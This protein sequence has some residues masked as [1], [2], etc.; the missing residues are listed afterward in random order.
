M[1]L[2]RGSVVTAGAIS[3]RLGLGAGSTVGGRVGI[4]IDP[5]LLAKL[6]AGRQVALV[7]GTNGKTTTTR[8]LAEALGGPGI[9]ATSLAGANMPAGLVAALCSTPAPT[10]PAVL[11]VDEGYLGDVD[12]SVRPRVVVALNLS[13]D[14]LDRVGEVRMVAARWREAFAATKA[15]VVANCDDP[16]VAWAAIAARHVVWVAAGGIW[17]A[18]AHHCPSCD[19]RVDFSAA[20]TS[21]WSCTCGLR[22]PRPEAALTDHALRIG[23][24]T[25]PFALALPGRFNR[26]NAAMAAVAASVLGIDAARALEAMSRVDDIAGRFAVVTDGSLSARL[27]LAKNPAGWTE[28]VDLL[29]GGTGP[30]VVAVNARDAD[31]RDPSWLW[32]VPFERLGERRVVATGERRDD[33]AVRLRH[34]GVAHATVRDQIDALHAAHRAGSGMG[35][36]SAGVNATVDY[37]GNYT[38]FQEL[39]RR[40]GRSP[41]TAAAPTKTLR[42]DAQPSWTV[43]MP[44]RPRSADTIRPDSSDT[45]ISGPGPGPGPGPGSGSGSGSGRARARRSALSVVVVHPDLLGTYGDGGNG[46]VLADRAEWRGIP[47]ELVVAP[48]DGPLP[49]SADLYC[50]GGGEDGPQSR[51]A[52][53]LA[54]GS[55]EDALARGATVLAVCAG[56]QILGHSFPGPGGVPQPGLGLLD[57]ATV[58]GTGPRAVGEVVAEVLAPTALGPAALASTALGP[59]ALGPT[60]LGPTALGP[61][62][63]GPT[64]AGDHALLTG[65]VN[66]AGETRIGPGARPL[67]RLLSGDG[68]TRS[69]APPA[70]GAVAGTVVATYLH[71]PVLARNPALADALLSMATG[72]VLEP[73]DDVEEDALRVERLRGS[74]RKIGTGTPRARKIG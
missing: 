7:S 54:D 60:A 73:L 29:A 25:V 17:H 13:R 67:A 55:L 59:T 57:V 40:V 2:A 37:V 23:D 31:G 38:A 71:G 45:T 24:R 48:S 50:L 16:L 70:D 39:R 63:L 53:Q 68:N 64:A 41:H 9:V 10:G 32:D 12:A 72:Q 65:F 20:E 49:R 5:R 35:G 21:G 62:A 61:T 26:A 27:L 18:D 44:A 8:L 11:E 1:W 58:R 22:R 33:L 19:A 47:V 69:G 4:A 51:S 14:Q 74:A 42:T 36:H 56:F 30:L 3:R 6:A 34:A 15:T 28:L 52:T 46:V 43:R 66:H